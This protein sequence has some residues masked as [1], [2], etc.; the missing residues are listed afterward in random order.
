MIKFLQKVKFIRSSE[1]LNEFYRSRADATYDVV[2]KRYSKLDV[3]IL[4]DFG[5]KTSQAL[6]SFS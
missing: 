2:F 4:D 1:L 5:L 3:L 6:T